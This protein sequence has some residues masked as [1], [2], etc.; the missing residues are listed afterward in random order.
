MFYNNFIRIFL[1][2]GCAFF[3]LHLPFVFYSLNSL[4]IFRFLQFM[5]FEMIYIYS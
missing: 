3:M 2:L 5:Y 1:T 4:C